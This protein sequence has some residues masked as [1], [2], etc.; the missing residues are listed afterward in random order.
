[1]RSRRAIL[2]AAL[3]LAAV[4]LS[5]CSRYSGR[6]EDGIAAFSAGDWEEAADIFSR[7][8]PGKGNAAVYAAYSR[9][10]VFWEQAQYGE[11]APCFEMS[12]DFMYARERL[13]F[14][15]AWNLCKAGDFAAAEAEFAALG[16]FESAPAY[17]AYCGALRAEQEHAYDQALAGYENAGNTEDA[18][19]RLLNLQTQI[20]SRAIELK[21]SGQYGQALILF[22]FLGDYLAS[23]AYAKECRGMDRDA[24]YAEAEGLEAAGDREGAWRLFSSLNGYRDAAQRAAD[25]AEKLH[26]PVVDESDPYAGY[27][28]N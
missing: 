2:L 5:G 1:M 16:D 14:C 13:R 6:Y 22:N 15:R 17:A 8:D 4:L 3:M 27:S 19:D 18:P 20:Y 26:I 7:C 24:L 11:A 28:N 21:N 25:L 23:A 9:G 12:G 10:L